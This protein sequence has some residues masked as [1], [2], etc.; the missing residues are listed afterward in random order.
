MPH[1]FGDMDYLAMADKSFLVIGDAN[2][3]RVA[4][5]VGKSQT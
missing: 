3:K 4:W 1:I 5:H 2:K